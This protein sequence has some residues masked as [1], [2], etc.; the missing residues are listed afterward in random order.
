MTGVA[1][2]PHY[3]HSGGGSNLLCLPLTP[4]WGNFTSSFEGASTIYGVE[5]ELSNYKKT[6]KHGLFAPKPYSLHDQN[7]PCA[8]CETKEHTSVMMIPGRKEC[9][10]KWESQYSGYLMTEHYKNVGRTEYICV[11]KEA[12]A[13]NAGFRNQNGALLF[14]VQGIAGS[15]PSPPYLKNGE[16]TCVV[17]SK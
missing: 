6:P 8:V 13:G 16:L 3:T 11:D 14:H 1:A 10:G 4:Q 15:L 7:V 2:G 9:L 5:Y 17:C 12:E